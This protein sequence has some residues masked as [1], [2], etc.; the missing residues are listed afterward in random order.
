MSRFWSL[1]IL[2]LYLSSIRNISAKVEYRYLKALPCIGTYAPGGVYSEYL[3]SLR[4]KQDIEIENGF[5]KADREEL[6][7][8]FL[9]PAKFVVEECE[10]DKNGD[11]EA[12][13]PK[14]CILRKIIPIPIRSSRVD[15]EGSLFSALKVNR[16]VEMISWSAAA[17]TDRNRGIYDNII[18]FLEKVLTQM[19]KGDEKIDVKK[20]ITEFFRLR[21][22]NYPSPYH[23]FNAALEEIIGLKVTGLL[24]EVADSINEASLSLGA[25]V[26]FC[27]KETS[28]EWIL[29]TNN[30]RSLVTAEKGSKDAKFIN[31]YMDELMGFHLATSIKFL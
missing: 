16:P 17:I 20:K 7:S 9:A 24:I 15:V 14:K 23:A 19:G 12:V 1:F 6:T 30:F 3:R 29:K 18:P 8:F 31:C 27:K 2:L 28:S 22:S 11:L 5:V 4:L 26:M 21:K 13:Q 10:V 25:A